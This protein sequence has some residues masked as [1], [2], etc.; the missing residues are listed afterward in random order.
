MFFYWRPKYSL[1]TVFQ[2]CAASEAQAELQALSLV[3]RVFLEG[4]NPEN[5]PETDK[6]MLIL[7]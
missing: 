2:M 5:N 4:R 6:E 3:I 1:S 7:V